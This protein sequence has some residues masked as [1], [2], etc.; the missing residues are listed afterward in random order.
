[1]A[2]TRQILMPLYATVYL[3]RFYRQ[4]G[5]RIGNNA[6]ISTVNEATPDL[7]EIG[8]GSFLADECI[9]GAM[10]THNGF[11]ELLPVRIGNRS[12]VGNSALIRGGTRIGD[13]SLLALMSTAT[14]A[15]TLAE[16]RGQWL[17]SP[18]F[19]LPRPVQDLQ[20]KSAELFSPPPEMVRKRYF[21]DAVRI[22]LPSIIWMAAM[23]AVA[24][25]TT[26]TFEHLPVWS[27]FI[28]LPLASVLSS[29]GEV[30]AMALIKLSISGRFKASVHPLWSDAV[31][32]DEIVNGVY[33]SL[34]TSTLAPLQG[35]PFLAPALRLLGC[36]IGKWCFLDTTYFS[37]FDLVQIGD[38]AAIN[39]GATIQT[40][41]FEDR[42]MKSGEVRLGDGCAIGNMS[43]VLYDTDIEAGVV[44]LPMSVVMKG[45]RLTAE[46]RWIGI[47]CQQASSVP[48]IAGMLSPPVGSSDHPTH[49]QSWQHAAQ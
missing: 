29:T 2:N 13:D 36:R 25:V 34:S 23:L 27:W 6:E 16:G 20:F 38:F 40:H 19:T 30:A 41:L 17:G 48:T 37:E 4:L 7:L 10:R 1:M 15:R 43:I 42:V 24:V 32:L 44:T 26:L 5:A 3:P 14:D 11:A 28:V 8:E 47:P 22:V 31:I 12:F 46:T 33:E 49:S 35:T 45:E 9:I 39:Q 21:V 18:A